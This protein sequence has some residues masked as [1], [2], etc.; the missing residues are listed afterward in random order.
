VFVFGF[1]R[2][3]FVDL[4]RFTVVLG[5]F[6]ILGRIMRVELGTFRRL[7]CSQSSF[8]RLRGFHWLGFIYRVAGRFTLRCDLGF[9]LVGGL[10]LGNGG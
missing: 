2:A 3:T 9:R 7:D 5:V 10:H 8:M 6:H 4:G 1:L